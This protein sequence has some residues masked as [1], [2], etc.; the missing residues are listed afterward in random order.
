MLGFSKCIN[1]RLNATMQ[2][3]A[4]YHRR[5]IYLGGHFTRLTG[6]KYTCTNVPSFPG[7]MYG[8]LS[9][10]QGNMMNN[11]LS[12]KAHAMFICTDLL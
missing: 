12:Q 7:K 1:V 2:F 8:G 4:S 5:T 9:L 3:R 6:H 11:Q 10:S